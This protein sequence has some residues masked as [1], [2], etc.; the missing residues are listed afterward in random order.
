M[1]NNNVLQRLSAIILRVTELVENLMTAN[2]PFEAESD[3]S[4]ITIGNFFETTSSALIIETSPE[5]SKNSFILASECKSSWLEKLQN[6]INIFQ[7]KLTKAK[8]WKFL[9]YKG[10]LK[11]SV[12][13]RSKP[14][15]TRIVS[16]EVSNT[17]KT[18]LLTPKPSILTPI[19][20][21]IKKNIL[22]SNSMNQ[23]NKGNNI[24]TRFLSSRSLL[25]SQFRKKTVDISR[26]IYLSK[27]QLW[28]RKSVKQPKTILNAK[29]QQNFFGKE[30]V[31]GF[32]LKKYSQ[33]RSNS[34]FSYSF[35]LQPETDFPKASD[36]NLEILVEDD[37]NKN[38]TLEEN[39]RRESIIDLLYRGKKTDDKICSSKKLKKL[40]KQIQ[41]Q[42]S[43]LNEI[44]KS[45]ILAGSQE[46]NKN[47]L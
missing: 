46:T 27:L 19:A 11:A 23:E 1:E 34:M 29:R 4:E 6:K 38:D 13:E 36:E 18:I 12:L 10:T 14:I 28:K 26:A 2:K 42:Y 31:L 30:S 8:K 15:N 47:S 24:V 21:N 25:Q 32:N 44:E 7:K 41:A 35:E 22:Q 45:N 17:P 39:K 20:L 40:R 3:F 43:L 9:K 5:S 33:K 37:K 16:S